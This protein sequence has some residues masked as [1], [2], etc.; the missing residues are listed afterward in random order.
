MNGGTNGNDANGGTSSTDLGRGGG[1]ATEIYLTRDNV[2]VLLITA[3]GGG[4]ANAGNPSG[5]GGAGGGNTTAAG[6]NGVGAGGGGYAGGLAGEFSYHSH[7]DACGYHTH[8]GNSTSGGACYSPN[9]C[10]G[11]LVQTEEQEIGGWYGHWDNDGSGICIQCGY[12]YGLYG[13]E[14]D[15]HPW[16]YGE[17][18]WTCQSCGGTTGDDTGTCR[19]TTYYLDCEY[20]EG[21]QCGKTEETIESFKASAGGTS[22]AAEGYGKKNA[23]LVSGVNNGE[24]K[25]TIESQ[26]V[27]YLEVTSLNNV[28][29]KDKVAP[30]NIPGYS[31]TLSAEDVC[32]IT[33]EEPDDFGTL[34]Y[35]RAESYESGTIKKLVD[36]NIT[37]NMLISGI[38]GYR[39]YVDGSVTG[40]VTSAH[41]WTA[42][43]WVDVHMQLTV[44]YLHIAAVDVAGNAGPTMN[45]MIKSIEDGDDIEI[46]DEYVENVPIKTE[47]LTLEDA[48]YVYGIG[49]ETYFVRADGATEH[50]LS[51]G[52]Y[53]DGTATTGYQVDWLKVI[54]SSDE[55]TEWYQT[56]IPKVDTD[57]GDKTFANMQLATDASAEELSLW[58]PTSAKARRTNH[59]VNVLVEQRFVLDSETD[60]VAIV[61][62]PQALAEVKDAYVY[63]GDAKDKENAITLIPDA[64]A[65]VIT[66]VEALENAGNIDMTEANKDFVITATD[67]GS[68]VKSFEITIINQD[69]QMTRTY[70]SDTGELTI[71]MT[72]DDYLFL[73]DFAVTAEAVDNVGNV[74]SHESGNLAFTL[75]AELQRARFPYNGDFKAGDGAV[76]TITTG[77]YADKV[78]IRFPDELLALNPNLDE[79][80]IYEFPEA[81]KT[82]VYEFNIPLGTPS[83]S[84]TIEVEAWKNGRKLTEELELPV[85]TIGS[86]IE[87]FRTRIRDNGV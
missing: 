73:G 84:Y 36:S 16:Y 5:N 31:E 66:G 13:N 28:L 75:K 55:G 74:G 47:Q 59:S 19:K 8:V 57:A 79:E 18:E 21:W 3:G 38:A 35:H 24:G 43:N 77:G 11:E 78:I 46:E 50:K 37:E 72:K 33:V 39:Y 41:T 65:P 27:G 53:V 64:K 68:G 34:Y 67:D 9:V 2:K 54:A 58:I 6:A 1:A 44:R 87:E 56:R 71:T 69:N 76:L 81:I 70:T 32:R 52:G 23:T 22:Y 85:K 60:G 40:T 61:L 30:G 83:G 48:D 82:E 25:V 14:S 86:I 49:N 26:D 17:D 10:G 62:Y 51:I 4:G 7:S 20:L 15:A 42:N 45:V 63:S 80:Y 12:N 29:A